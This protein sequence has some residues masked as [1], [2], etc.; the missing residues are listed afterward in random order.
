LILTL[1]SSA[2]LMLYVWDTTNSTDCSPWIN[3][4]GSKGWQDL[5]NRTHAVPDISEWRFSIFVLFLSSVGLSW[6]GTQCP[7]APKAR[8]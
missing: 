5:T 8:S 3:P 2:G 6:Q 7:L 1:L 4:G